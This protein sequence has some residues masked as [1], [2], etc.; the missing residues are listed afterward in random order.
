MVARE[1]TDVHSEAFARRDQLLEA[2]ATINYVLDELGDAG[3]GDIQIIVTYY[4]EREYH[5]VRGDRMAYITT[6]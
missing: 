4:S 3:L 6:E 1:E 5:L 2:M